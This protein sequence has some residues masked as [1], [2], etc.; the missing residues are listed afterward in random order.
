MSYLEVNQ[1]I[2]IK[3]HFAL[4]KSGYWNQSINRC[5]FMPDCHGKKLISYLYQNC[6]L[7]D[8]LHG[9]LYSSVKSV[10]IVNPPKR[11]QNIN[12]WNSLHKCKIRDAGEAS[13]RVDW[14][15]WAC[16]SQLKSSFLFAAEIINSIEKR[17]IER[18]PMYQIVWVWFRNTFSHINF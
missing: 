15:R 8:Q 2:L 10:C 5:F 16:Q 12:S 14:N 9:Y 13:E 17:W 4:S 3:M 11:N 7:T 1:Y 18:V 6:K